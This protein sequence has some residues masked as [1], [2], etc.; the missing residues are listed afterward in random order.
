MLSAGGRR[1]R[2]QEKQLTAFLFQMHQKLTLIW[3]AIL[4]ESIKIF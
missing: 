1:V 2:Q 4:E 3:S